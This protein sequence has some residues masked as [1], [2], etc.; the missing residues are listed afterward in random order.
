M[1]DPSQ[2]HESENRPVGHQPERLAAEG[3]SV[4]PVIEE[5]LIVD[6]QAIETGRVR[7]AKKIHETEETVNIPLA[8]D[9]VNVERVAINQLVDILPPVRHEGDT[10]I[11]PVVEEILVVEKRLMLVEELRVTT[12]RI[13]TTETQQVTLRKEEVTVERVTTT[14]Q[15]D[16]GA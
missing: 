15:S 16:G 11:I 1:T 12:R 13:E 5:R 4:I 3:T 10:M 6:R 7:I 14:N 2:Q 8:R 9:E